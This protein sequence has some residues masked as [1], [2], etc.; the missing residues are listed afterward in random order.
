MHNTAQ[1]VAQTPKRNNPPRTYGQVSARPQIPQT[2]QEFSK[3]RSVFPVLLHAFGCSRPPHV[4][5]LEVGPDHAEQAL[6]RVTAPAQSVCENASTVVA[7]DA[8]VAAIRLVQKLVSGPLV[9]PHWSLVLDPRFGAGIA[10]TDAG[11]DDAAKDITPCVGDDAEH[12][13]A[14]QTSP[15]N[16]DLDSSEHERFLRSRL[17]LYDP[18]PAPLC[19]FQ[20]QL[21]NHCGKFF[22]AV[23]YALTRA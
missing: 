19:R 2:P 4:H 13:L 18:C 16:I 5:L 23:A 20:V 11:P 9:A 7:S 14:R 8:V 1:G 6:G 10:A 3:P 17:L 21:I 22:R 15:I 12:P